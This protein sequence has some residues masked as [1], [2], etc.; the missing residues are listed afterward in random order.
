V[1]ASAAILAGC[2]GAPDGAAD[3]VDLDD[4]CPSALSGPQPILGNCSTRDGR[5]RIAAPVAPHVTWAK[6][7]LPTELG[8]SGVLMTTDDSGHVY[9]Q[10]QGYD[11]KLHRIRA[12]DGTVE[13]TKS[14]PF[15][16]TVTEAIVTSRG[17]VLHF[18]ADA[19]GKDA[20]LAVDPSSGA[21]TSTATGLQLG[22]EVG[23]LAV[24]EDGSLYYGTSPYGDVYNHAYVT[25]LGPDGALRWK[26]AD[27][28]PL[29]PKPPYYPTV[30]PPAL[31]KG[32]LVVVIL[33]DFLDQTVVMAFDPATGAPRWTTPLAGAYNAPVPMVKADGTIVTILDDGTASTLVTLEPETGT[34]TLHTFPPGIQKILGVTK[35]GTVI[36][37]RFQ[38]GGIIGIGSDGTIHWGGPGGG[39]GSAT[40]TIAKDGTVISTTWKHVVAMDSA[41]GKPKWKV[42]LPSPEVHA[43]VALTSDG[44]I[45]GWQS[46]GTVFAASD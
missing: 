23:A 22:G 25:R 38:E 9:M 7:L 12:A 44:T 42:A 39:P 33:A 29:L 19:H 32:D 24:G 37:P 31:G 35:Q 4:P 27:L 5:A 36:T 18:G 45:I 11:V 30:S 46:D 13:W 43:E 3:L 10:T 28:I 21:S 1:C 14:S 16:D 34:P 6:K 17:A 15:A 26:S 40:A 20:L 8:F 41:T 2:G